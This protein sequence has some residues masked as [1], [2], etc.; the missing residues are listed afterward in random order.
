MLQSSG[1]GAG[2]G[3][4]GGH[5]S[6]T[7][8]KSR[9]IASWFGGGS[10]AAATPRHASSV[11]K[12]MSTASRIV[13][14][15]RN[16]KVSGTSSNGRFDVAMTLAKARFISA[17]IW[18]AAP[19]KAKIDCFSS[20]TAKTVRFSGR[21]PAPAKNSALSAARMLHC[22]CRCVLGF[23]EQQVIEPVVELV[24]HPGGARPRHQRE[25][26]RDL[27]VEIERA[28]LGLHPRE[29][30]QDRSCDH[31]Q[32]GAALKRQRRAPTLAQDA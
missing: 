23:V 20:P 17:N 19:W 14:D 21:A 29:G 32:R 13:C 4:I 26:T 22:G 24:Q 25:R 10:S 16:E 7:P 11:R 31:E 27:I 6:T 1:S 15:D 18:G 9:R 3:A 5:S 28:T 2:V 12:V 30:R 8:F